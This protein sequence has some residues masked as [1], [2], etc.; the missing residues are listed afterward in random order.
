ME[1]PSKSRHMV[2]VTAHTL[3]ELEAIK[4]NL[5]RKMGIRLTFTQVIGILINVY[6]DKSNEQL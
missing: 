6:K 3:D 1:K 4:N 5:Q 2:S